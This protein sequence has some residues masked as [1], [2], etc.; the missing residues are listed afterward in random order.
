MLNHK[1]STGS[2]FAGYTIELMCIHYLLVV[3]KIQN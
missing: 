1:S 3:M 2:S